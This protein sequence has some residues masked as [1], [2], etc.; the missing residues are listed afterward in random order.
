MSK[1]E[2]QKVSLSPNAREQL[3]RTSREL[4]VS[5]ERVLSDALEHYMRMVRGGRTLKSELKAWEEVSDE[6]LLVFEER[7]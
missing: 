2:L 7:I 4:C 1:K 6:D 3:R 5:E